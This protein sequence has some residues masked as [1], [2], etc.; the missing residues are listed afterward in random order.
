M[1]NFIILNTC[2]RF[3]SRLLC[4]NIIAHEFSSQESNC[5]NNIQDECIVAQDDKNEEIG[6]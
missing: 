2:R 4:T 6:G 3:K 1:T 5:L